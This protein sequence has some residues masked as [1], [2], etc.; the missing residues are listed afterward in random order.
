MSFSRQGRK[1]KFPPV[2]EAL[3]EVHFESAEFDPTLP[4][5]FYEAIR[6]D[7]PTKQQIETLGVQLM[8]SGGEQMAAVKKGQPTIRFLSADGSR[9]VQIGSG[10]ISVHQMRPYP[11]FKDWLPTFE[12]VFGQYVNIIGSPSVKQVTIRYLNEIK[13]PAKEQTIN[14]G[15]YFGLYPQ[16]PKTLGEQHNQFVLRIE[17]IP[18]IPRHYLLA[19]F[20]TA[21][22]PSPTAAAFALDLY[23]Q[24][25]FP[26]GLPCSKVM[27][28]VKE[29][30][31]NV[32]WGFEGIITDELRRIFK[33]EKR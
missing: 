19:T 15:P 1:Y 22:K 20:G 3:A 13:I 30:H 33:E 6:G 17:L 23:D 10:V 21:P 9:A 7:F 4:G 31:G 24:I 8:T 28:M 32:E 29:A 18:P 5:I 16:V 11:Q 26:S 27:D 2:V 25:Q 12:K 14:M